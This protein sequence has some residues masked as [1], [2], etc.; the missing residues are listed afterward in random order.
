[1]KGKFG[2][3]YDPNIAA[4]QKSTNKRKEFKI[5]PEKEAYFKGK[6]GAN[7]DP[8]KVG[9][10]KVKSFKAPSTKPVT[11]GYQG[12]NYDPDYLKKKFGDKYDPSR[13]PKG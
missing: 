5:S 13:A 10:K 8:A 1:M 9:Q 6:F 12:K 3:N 4:R 2:K 11:K 7:Y